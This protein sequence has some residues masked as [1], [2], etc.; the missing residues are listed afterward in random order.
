[1]TT[2][3]AR[4][5]QTNAVRGCRLRYSTACI[6]NGNYHTYRE[7]LPQDSGIDAVVFFKSLVLKVT[8]G[9]GGQFVLCSACLKKGLGILFRL[10]QFIFNIIWKKNVTRSSN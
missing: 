9:I 7:T 8:R 4:C 6:L 5:T 10:F 2:P 1:V 3:L